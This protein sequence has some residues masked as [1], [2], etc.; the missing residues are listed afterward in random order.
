VSPAPNPPDPAPEPGPSEQTALSTK[1]PADLP[2]PT[3][4]P[5]GALEPIRTP[6]SVRR[7]TLRL[8]GAV[9][10]AVPL[11]GEALWWRNEETERFHGVRE[12]WFGKETYAGGADKVSHVFGGY[13]FAKELSIAFERI[14]NSPARSRALATG[15]TAVTGMLVEMGDGFSTYGYSWEDVFSDLVGAGF[16]AGVGAARLDDTLGVRFG[17]VKT[18][19][20]PK[21]CRATAYGSDYSREIYSFDVKLD[22][23]FRRL[24]IARPGPARFLLLSLTYGSKG[25]RFSP[26]EVRQRNVGVD[27]GLNMVEVLKAVG[28]SEDTWWGLPLVKFFSYY[29]L[30]YTAWGFR[31]DFNHR[32]WSGFGTGG[33]FDPGRVIYQ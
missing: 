25:Y 28:V 33:K 16:A 32:K 5:P 20:P 3:L 15:M 21:C 31:Y 8:S 7:D 30:E 9:L 23:A 12:N 11:F 17:F 6:E 26:V 14:G 4:P 1:P 13:T 18:D 24:G 22:G 29:R 2:A 10:F 19:I 27:V